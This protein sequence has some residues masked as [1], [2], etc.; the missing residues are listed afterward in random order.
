ML[1]IVKEI[2]GQKKIIPLTTDTGTGAPV[3]T[4]IQQYKKVPMSGYLYC[5]GSTFDENVYPA[6]YMYL[7]TNVLPDYREC[8]MVGAEQNTTDT[9]ATHD[10]YGEGEFKDDQLETHQHYLS[11][12][13]NGINLVTRG[14]GGG[15]T[16]WNVNMTVSDDG[17]P[18]YAS[19]VTMSYCRKGDTTHG[20]QKAVYV[21]IKAT[22]GLAENQQDNVLNDVKD[23]VDNSNSYSTQEIKTGGT[24]IDGKP[25]YRK[26]VTTTLQTDEQFLIIEISQPLK[27]MV[28]IKGILSKGNTDFVIP[29]CFVDGSSVFQIYTYCQGQHLYISPRSSDGTYFT[30]G[31]TVRVIVEYTKTT[32]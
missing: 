24:W 6:L 3:G 27:S 10:V 5:D 4:L 7:G 20:K 9:I 16:G 2:N 30:A 19:P 8:V 25:I 12:Q 26:V 17:N 31:C 13:P 1:G 15:S 14:S 28:S 32:D 22:S 18:I 23:Y 11:I 21:Y 29:Y